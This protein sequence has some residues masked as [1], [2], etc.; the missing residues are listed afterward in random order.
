MRN[1]FSLALT[2]LEMNPTGCNCYRHWATGTIV[3]IFAIV[4]I[5]TTCASPVAGQDR[6]ASG[7][8]VIATKSTIESS[9]TDRIPIQRNTN[10]YYARRTAVD[11]TTMP[12]TYTHDNSGQRVDQF[13]KGIEPVV[14]ERPDYVKSGYRHSRSSLQTGFSADHYHVV[15]QWGDNVRPYGEW[16]YPARPYSAPYSVWGP[17]LPYAVGINNGGGPW[18]WGGFNNPLGGA[19]GFNPL[20]GNMFGGQNAIPP[21]AF[22]F[23]PP[24][25]GAN[26]QPFG[27]GPQNALSPYQ[28]E[29][30]PAAP[31]Y[32]P[33]A[34]G[35]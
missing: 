26:S 10:P 19:N 31:I 9:N 7:T 34:N 4:A 8:N 11:W 27:V 30:Y 16:R 14:M 21:M 25:R 17:Q 24:Q 35:L 29:Y 6:S 22:P 32:N 18:I 28:D 13:S 20:L 5:E 33:P 15:E 12:S 23:L 1:L 3:A 2:N